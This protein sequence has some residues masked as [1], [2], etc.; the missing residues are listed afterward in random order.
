MITYCINTILCS[1]LLLLLYKILLENEKMHVFKR[2]YLCISVIVSFTAPLITIPIQEPQQSLPLE[3]VVHESVELITTQSTIIAEKAPGKMAILLAAI[4]FLGLTVCLFKLIKTIYRLI[5]KATMTKSVPFYEARLVLLEGDVL[6]HSFLNN[7]FLSKEAYVKEQ[8]EKDILVHELAHV[9]QYHSL[10]ILV[11][12]LVQCIFW[13]N[14]FYILYLRAIQLNHEFLADESVLRSSE[15]PVSYQYLLLQKSSGGKRYALTSSFN[16]FIIK[17][18]LVMIAKHTSRKTQ[19]LFSM[20]AVFIS[21]LIISLFVSKETV[22]QKAEPAVESKTEVPSTEGAS[23]QEM[24]EY[25]TMAAKYPISEYR[26]LSMEQKDRMYV[27]FTKMTKEQKER[28]L[29]IVRPRPILVAKAK[30]TVTDDQLK[31]WVDSKKYFVRIDGYKIENSVLENY[32]GSDFSYYD[33]YKP[34]KKA[35]DYGK[36]EAQINLVTNKTF[37]KNN[38]YIKRPK[39]GSEQ[40]EYVLAWRNKAGPIPEFPK[41]RSWLQPIMDF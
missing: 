27:L 24:T 4:Y 25:E 29:V 7:I 22:A 11:V 21:L 12:Q 15:N 33:Y 13:F 28:Q 3:Y 30:K 32:H 18:R 40:S 5:Q 1:A 39:T 20:T 35:T 6:P 19:W 41:T 10:D 38:E 16:Y 37:D 23:A 2:G 8:I 31:N 36:Y 26:K 14:P 34:T 9:K 17:K